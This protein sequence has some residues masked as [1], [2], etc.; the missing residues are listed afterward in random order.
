VLGRVEVVKALAAPKRRTKVAAAQVFMVDSNWI[1][2]SM[3]QDELES[4][5]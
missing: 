3:V 2:L 4:E 1:G 5:R